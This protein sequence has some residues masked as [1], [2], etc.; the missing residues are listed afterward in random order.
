MPASSVT[1]TGRIRLQAEATETGRPAIMIDELSLPTQGRHLLLLSPNQGKPL[2]SCLVPVDTQAFPA[3]SVAFLNLTSR[4]MRCSVDG[5]HVDLR[6]GAMDRIPAAGSDRIA[7]N[8]RLHLKSK[9]AWVLEN[10]TTLMVGPRRRC[11]IVLTEDAPKGPVRR[12][13]VVDVNPAKHL[14]PLPEPAAKSSVGETVKAEPP[15]PDPPAK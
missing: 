3:G 7:V 15:L 9:Q 14:A 4:E 13:L 11:L 1:L 8:H 2:R 6:P 5:A 12:A 10:S